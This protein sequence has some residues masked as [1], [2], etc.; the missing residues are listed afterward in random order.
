MTRVALRGIRSHLGRFLLSILAVLLGVGFVAGTFSLR[1]MMSATFDDIVES[2]TN[3]DTYVQGAKIEAT[4][5]DAMGGFAGAEQFPIAMADVIAEA[6]GVAGVVPDVSGSIVL[7]GA[8]GTAVM[9]SGPPSFGMGLVPDETAIW[10]ADGREPTGPGEIALETAALE[11]SGLAVGDT[12]TVVLAGQIREVEVVGEV[13]FAAPMAGAIMVGLDM[14]TAMAAYAP[15][16]MVDLV[17]VYAEDGVSQTELAT[18]VKATLAGV[19]GMDVE[20]LTGDQ[21]RADSRE[22]WQSMLGFI[23]TFLLVFAGIALFVGT[24]MISNTFAMVVRQRQREFAMLRA[25]GASPSQVFASVL[26]QA[27]VIGVVGSLLG[28]GAG[29]GLVAVL[30]QIFAGMGMEL[31][32]RIPLDGFTIAVSVIT[33]TVVSLVAAV[34]PARKAALTAPVEAMRDDVVSHDRAS[35]WRTAAGA[36]LLAGGLVAV[37]VATTGVIENNRPSLLGAGAGAIVLSVLMLAPTIA[38]AVLGVL[39]APVVRGM[40]PLGGLAKGNVTRHPKRTAS[41]AGALMIGMALVGAASVIAASAQASVRDV[42]DN[43]SQADLLLQSATRDVPAELV[44]DVAALDGLQRVDPFRVAYST[45]VDGEVTPVIGAP[46]GFFD[47]TL[48]VPVVDGATAAMAD[49]QAVVQELAAG[50]KG[51]EV[52]DTLTVAGS[53]GTADVTIGAVIDSRAIGASVILPDQVFDTVADPTSTMTDTVFLLAEPGAD[54]AQIRDQVTELAAPYVVVSVMDG[55]EFGDAIAQQ[56]NQMLVILYALLGLSIVIAVLGIVNTL[57]LSISERTREIGLLRAVGL[58]RLQLAGVVTI[59]SV[60]TAVFGTVLGIG[61]GA[62]LAATMPTVFR[63]EGFTSLVIPWGPLGGLLG[64]AVVV[65]A[66]AA[67]WPAVRAARM[68]VLEA[69]AYE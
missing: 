54:I 64:L 58:G 45:A 21:M 11:R 16:G 3:A 39:A 31:S 5:G 33:G 9:S 17:G 50:P 52:G 49:G 43:E 8:D 26:G 38:G 13:G 10:I 29:V 32:G 4:G 51:W 56:V 20:V 28:V 14:E 12:T 23:S 15:D 2:G 40:R 19:P 34:V 65:G 61:L 35:R 48:T 60:L 59:E 25:V 22:Q 7:V 53:R 36:V 63:D 67:V 44:S 37:A 69:I 57:A 24:F 46:V 42:V 18:S 47:Q 62:G 1:A 6:D 68:D 27:A 66:L 30:K 41:T 55:E